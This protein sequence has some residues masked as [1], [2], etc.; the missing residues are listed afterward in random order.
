MSINRDDLSA[1]FYNDSS[2]SMGKLKT[3]QEK[4]LEESTVG[5]NGWPYIFRT[6]T[7]NLD[8]CNL[9]SFYM[10]NIEVL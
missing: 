2:R 10:F 7:K 1:S 4:V 3:Q 6:Q 8:T 9:L 5:Y